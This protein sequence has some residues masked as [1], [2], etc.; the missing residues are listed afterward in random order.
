MILRH[1]TITIASLLLCIGL[2]AQDQLPLASAGLV[3]RLENFPADSIASRHVDIWTP[4]DYDK[5][6][7]HHVIYVQDGQMLFDSTQTWNQQEW[8]MDETITKLM[9]DESIPPTIVVAIHNSGKERMA[10]YFPQKPFEILPED[11]QK[12]FKEMPEGS[13]ADAYVKWLVNDLRPYIN[14][15][16]A[17]DT[18]ATATTIMGSSMGAL[19]SMYAWTEYPE[20]FGSAICMS[21]HWIGG[22]ADYDNPVPASFYYHLE[23]NLPDPAKHKI[24]FDHGTEGLDKLY[25]KHQKRV[26][27]MMQEEGYVSDQNFKSAVIEGA[28]HDENA[29]AARLAE[30]ILFILGSKK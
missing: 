18:S 29:W 15:N 6:Q 27:Q 9:N 5:S 17:V 1:L 8:Q 23:K 22:Y 28:K 7:L 30:P 14:K 19:I 4:E 10:D 2:I 26:D 3:E 25:A 24:Y 12:D 21:T 16:F 13:N 11:V 20:V